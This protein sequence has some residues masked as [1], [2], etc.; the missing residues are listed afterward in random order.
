MNEPPPVVLRTADLSAADLPERRLRHE[1][2][3]HS[4]ERIAPGAYVDAD[5]WRRLAELEQA[6]LR[7]RA[8]MARLSEHLV[9]SHDSAAALWG[10]PFLDAR[11]TAVHVIDPAR[12]TPDSRGGLIRHVGELADDDVVV[13]THFLATS[14]ARTAVD[15][16]LRDGFLTALMFFDHGLR[17]KLFTMEQ[18]EVILSRFPRARRRREALTAMRM[19][20]PLPE[21]GGESLSRGQF[22][23]IGLEAP[24]LQR[25]FRENG[26]VFARADFFWEEPGIVGE[27]DGDVKY[28]ES[29]MRNGRSAEQ[30]LVDEKWRSEQLLDHPEVNRVV[31][32]NYATARSVTKLA[33]RL[34]RAGVPRRPLR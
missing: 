29:R 34:I 4:L 13:G 5:A 23:L 12:V 32:W 24:E 25:E 33:D 26:R 10:M 1:H 16:A 18:V 21:N 6:R 3:R 27:L 19:A 9:A 17:E 31:R 2:E 22:V 14:P 28:L 7:V 8:R 11:P 20:S 30:V 15:M